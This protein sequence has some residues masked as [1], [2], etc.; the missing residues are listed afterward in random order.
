MEGLEG[1]VAA[2][3]GG[4]RGIGKAIAQ[5]FL[6][7]GVKVGIGDIDASG[8]EETVSELGRIGPEIIGIPLDGTDSDQATSFVTEVAERLGG[9]DIL[10]NNAGITRDTLLLRMKNEDWDQVLDVNLKGT[11]Y[12][13]RAAAK[14]MLKKRSGRI[15]NISS[16]VGQIGNPGQ[17]NYSASKSGVIGF[18][19]STARELAGRGVTV[20][21]VAPG[22]IDTEMTRCLSPEAKDALRGQI[23]LGRLGTAKDV[24]DAIVFL[25]SDGAKYIT[26][27][28]INV[29]GGMVMG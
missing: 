14:L 11:F 8:I 9:L 19:C 3:T 17:A 26:G 2:I 18:T 21:A 20:N 22:F 6:E 15:I 16:V 13:T 12:C 25:A 24:A 7:S 23:P 1:N 5:A 27:Q 10:V 29:D 4:A 28:V